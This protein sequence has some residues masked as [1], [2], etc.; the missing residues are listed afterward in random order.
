MRKHF[1]GE[2]FL[3]SLDSGETSKSQFQSMAICTLSQSISK[4]SL[5]LHMPA[6]RQLQISGYPLQTLIRENWF[7]PEVFIEKQKIPEVF[8]GKLSKSACSLCFLKINNIFTW[9]N[10]FKLQ[11]R[12]QCIFMRGPFAWPHLCSSTPS[13]WRRHYQFLACPLDFVCTYIV[14]SVSLFCYIND[15]ILF[16]VSLTSPCILETVSCQ[17]A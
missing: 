17:S 10:F 2:D 1:A 8:V 7:I 13:S 15:S 9:Q 3:I 6:H 14:Y 5:R 16:W 4:L 11:N 12:M